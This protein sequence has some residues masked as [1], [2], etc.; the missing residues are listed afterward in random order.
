MHFLKVLI[1]TILL[2]SVSSVNALRIDSERAFRNSTVTIDIALNNVTGEYNRRI[3]E[4]DESFWAKSL[5]GYGASFQRAVTS[6]FAIGIS[7]AQLHNKISTGAS[8]SSDV[9][10]KFTSYSGF[11]TFSFS[12][13]FYRKPFFKLEYGKI[14]G[15]TDDL[16]TSVETEFTNYYSIA[17]GVNTISVKYVVFNFEVFYKSI[18]TDDIEI[19]G[20]SSSQ[21]DDKLNTFGFQLGLGYN[22][23]L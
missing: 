10:S 4:I 21:I 14:K 12:K 19:F 8:K 23:N 9:S 11:V 13:V 7:F 15:K 2:I 22:F 6:Q 3:S 18:K 20:Y 17:A 5:Y 1:I 16:D